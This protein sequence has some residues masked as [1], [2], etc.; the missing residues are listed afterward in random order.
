MLA[1]LN[2]NERCPHDCLILGIFKFLLLFLVS[3]T[4]SQGGFLDSTKMPRFIERCKRGRLLC[5]AL[6]LAQRPP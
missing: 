3:L 2:I 1:A 5:T 6:G 4:L